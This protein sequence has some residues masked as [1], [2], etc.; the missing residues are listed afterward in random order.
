MILQTGQELGDFEVL[1]SLGQGA[2]G[3]V[4]RARDRRLGREVALKVISD[5]GSLGKEALF[6]FERE[7]RILAS[8]NHP[9]I[10]II[11]GLVEVESTALIVLELIE[12]QSLADILKRQ[13]L[14]V[15]QA[16]EISLQ[17]AEALEAA[18]AKGIVHRDLKPA[19]IKVTPEGKVKVLDFGVA[20]CYADA[21]RQPSA[22][23]VDATT[24]LSTESGIVIG[25]VGYMS[26]EQA[27]GLS[28]DARPLRPRARPRIEKPEGIAIAAVVDGCRL[29]Y[30]APAGRSRVPRRREARRG[31]AHRLGIEFPRSA[32]RERQRRRSALLR[33]VPPKTI[34]LIR[35]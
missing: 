3:S 11:H 13:R 6:R 17:V 30:R 2:M 34:G 14:P 7:A 20:K 10:A 35:F 22:G 1:G 4:Y 25:T 15:R 19:N 33:P 23:A 24:D 9:N 31:T 28:V 12:G 8:L 21:S 16:L 18:H 32:R 26:P 29:A 5:K 27:R